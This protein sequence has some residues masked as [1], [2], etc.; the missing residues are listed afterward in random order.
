VLFSRCINIAKPCDVSVA[1]QIRFHGISL[2]IFSDALD[3]RTL[4]GGAKPGVT[5]I[6]YWRL[7]DKRLKNGRVDCSNKEPAELF[8]VRH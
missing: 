3:G 2:M 6:F 1:I 7:H 8:C 5:S 4:L